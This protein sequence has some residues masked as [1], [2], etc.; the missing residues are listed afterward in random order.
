MMALSVVML[1]ETPDDILLMALGKGQ[2]KEAKG[3]GICMY[4]CVYVY[5]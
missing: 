4:V 3:G 2:F 5:M 1:G